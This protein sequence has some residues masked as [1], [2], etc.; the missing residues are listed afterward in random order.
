MIYRNLMTGK[1]EV[2][3]DPETVE[4]KQVI[5]M[6][7]HSVNQIR[8]TYAAARELAEAIGRTVLVVA[9]DI[10]VESFD[11]AEMAM[12]GWVRDRRQVQGR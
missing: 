3:D 11:A 8:H 9:A 4:A 10:K 1:M 2:I 12:Y 7:Y 6:R 5:V